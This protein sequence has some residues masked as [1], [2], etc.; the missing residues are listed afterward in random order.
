MKKLILLFSLIF[1][2]LVSMAQDSR[3]VSLIPHAGLTISK[4]QGDAITAGK[5]WKT[6]WTAGVEADIPFTD[7]YSIFTGV[8]YSLVGTNLDANETS[9]GDGYVAKTD[10][11]KINVGY[12]SV[13]LCLNKHF[14]NGFAFRVG[15]E[16]G[17]LVL[18]KAHAD[19]KG[20][21]AMDIG[22]GQASTLLWENFKQR[23]SEDVSG[24]FRNIVWDIPVGVSYEWRNI[25]LSG[26]YRFEIRKAISQAPEG[27]HFMAYYDAL[28]ARNHAILVTLGYRFRL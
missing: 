16:A 14:D 8:D 6:G 1:L 11:A 24:S 21:R 5:K 9:S 18:A 26:S 3:R 22:G 25:V 10:N 7:H 12:V 19:V 20:I 15:I 28:T 2:P 4:M 17:F 13:P 27:S 23:Q